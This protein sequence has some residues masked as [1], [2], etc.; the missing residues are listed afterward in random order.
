MSLSTVLAVLAALSTLAAPAEKQS[1]DSTVKPQTNAVFLPRS[2]LVE[3]DGEPRGRGA[4]SL[5]IEDRTRKFKVRVSAEGFETQ[6]AVVEAARVADKDFALALRPAGYT[7]PVDARDASSMALAASALLR[8]GRVDD[9]ADYAE[10]S[11]RGGNTPLANRVL[12]D[13]WRRRG[14]RDQ[15]TRF[16]TMYLSLADHPRDEAEIR[17]WL[18]QDK[19]GDI[20]IPAE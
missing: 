20:T 5:E 18:L 1:W 17:A 6:E 15:A 7:K 19:A 8:A 11:L 2:A 13:V 9:A 4:V 3:V 14:D 12:G 10:Q 16:Y